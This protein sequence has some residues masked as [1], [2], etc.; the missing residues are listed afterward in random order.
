MQESAHSSY[1][2]WHRS[3]ISKF[4]L[5]NQPHLSYLVR[6]VAYMAR[7]KQLGSNKRFRYF[8]RT[9]DADHL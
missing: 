5:A 9:C 8:L 2:A 4:P 3:G 7:C 6:Q 1:A